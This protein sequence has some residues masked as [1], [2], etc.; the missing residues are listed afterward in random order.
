MERDLPTVTIHDTAFTVDIAKLEFREVN[1][2]KNRISFNDVQ[3]KG[4]HLTILFDKTTRNAFTGTWSE[5]TKSENVEVVNLPPLIELDRIGVGQLLNP[6]ELYAIAEQINK[7]HEHEGKGPRQL[8]TVKLADDYFFVDVRLSEFRQQ[9]NP[10]NR[11]PFDQ[12]FLAGENKLGLFYDTKT[13]NSFEGSVRELER[14]GDVKL[15]EL[16]PI[17]GINPRQ[18][19]QRLKQA[20]DNGN[21][22]KADAKNDQEPRRSKR[23]GRGM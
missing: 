2:P 12:L 5:M 10:H 22:L 17:D 14:R 11:I 20:R 1:N 7:G 23:R 3:D 18:L 8:P 16:P 4:N 19:I 13:K 21:V 6:R 15:V 9:H